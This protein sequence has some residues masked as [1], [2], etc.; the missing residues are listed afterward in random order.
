[1]ACGLLVHQGTF[2]GHQKVLQGGAIRV[3][4]SPVDFAGGN[5][6][7]HHLR[8][9]PPGHWNRLVLA[10]GRIQ[11]CPVLVVMP[12]PALVMQPGGRITLFLPLCSIGTADSLVIF[13][14]GP[15]LR[16]GVL[17]KVMGQPLTDESDPETVYHHQKP[18]AGNGFKML[19]W[20]HYKFLL[21]E[22]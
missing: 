2:L 15:K 22:S 1:M 8:Q 7:H 17:G 5:A 12:V 18:V 14:S 4:L 6:I 21:R 13:G 19:T 9:I 16:R 10:G 20:F 3:L 11:I